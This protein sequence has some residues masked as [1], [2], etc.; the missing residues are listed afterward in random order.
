MVLL[1]VSSLTSMFQ[2][3]HLYARDHNYPS[4]HFWKYWS[5]WK[6]AKFP[7]CSQHSVELELSTHWFASM[8][9]SKSDC[10]EILMCCSQADPALRLG[11]KI[12]ST[13]A[14]AGWYRRSPY[15]SYRC[16]IIYNGHSSFIDEIS[17]DLYHDLM[18]RALPPFYRW[19]H[20]G[21]ERVSDQV[22]VARTGSVQ[23]RVTMADGMQ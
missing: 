9:I 14:E 12:S 17:S 11:R 1:R 2:I 4:N 16:V 23:T 21:S 22:A 7:V 20:W 3:P 10:W 13:F 8:N 19:R 5:G 15:R 18:S 6:D